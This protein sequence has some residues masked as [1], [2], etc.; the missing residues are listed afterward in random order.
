MG[1]HI[2]RIP[3]RVI[4][5]R[6]SHSRAR[7]IAIRHP[8]AATLERRGHAEDDDAIAARARYGDGVA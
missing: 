4:D 5:A 1:E 7:T 2:D 6:Q 3:P 8:I